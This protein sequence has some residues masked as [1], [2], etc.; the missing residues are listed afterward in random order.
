MKYGNLILEKREYV[1]IK[2]VL[3]LAGDYKDQVQKYSV[4]KLTKELETA[5]ILDEKEVA[6]DIIRLNSE[7]TIATN[8]GWQHTF[9]VVLPTES[10]TAQK[11][12]SV[13]LPM[14]AAVIGYATGD[15]IQW[16][17]PG[18]EKTIDILKVKQ[19]N[20]INLNIA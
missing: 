15:S 17:F 14:G 18:G 1:D 7:V 6:D 12:V 19:N 16:K 20:S 2:R 3:N 9:Q 8:D 10:N 13:L 5:L 4:E 11:K